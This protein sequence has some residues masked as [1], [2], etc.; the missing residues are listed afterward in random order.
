MYKSTL[1]ILALGMFGALAFGCSSDDSGGGG[2]KAD[3]TAQCKRICAKADSCQLEFDC[4]ECDKV[5]DSALNCNFS[6]V[7]AKVDECAQGKCEDLGTCGDQI[8]EICPQLQDEETGSG[9]AS[10]SGGATG[11]GG[12]TSASGGKT[13][14]SGGSVGAGTGGSTSGGDCSACAQAE[15]CCKGLA[16]YAGEDP[17]Q[18]DGLNDSCEGA[19]DQQDLVV[20][21]C[22]SILQS[23]STLPVPACK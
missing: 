6:K 10:G 16:D 3:Y 18:C 15:A 2:T 1:G 22:E 14:G 21:Q 8:F 19:G 7:K 11:S 4:T 13:S 17:A 23:A 12:K 5:P 20:A 9:G